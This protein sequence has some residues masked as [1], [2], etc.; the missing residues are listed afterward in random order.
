VGSVAQRL[1][2]EGMPHS[3]G[4][5]EGGHHL[6]PVRETFASGLRAHYH[7]TN[8]SPSAVWD[9]LGDRY[10]ELYVLWSKET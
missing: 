5:P 6:V 7:V 2:T 9:V 4:F 10:T 8:R 1:P 3:H